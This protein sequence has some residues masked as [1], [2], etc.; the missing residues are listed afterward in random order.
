M[1]VTMEDFLK[2]VQKSAQTGLE[3]LRYDWLPECCAIIDMRRDEVEKWMPQD[4]E[5][6]TTN[7]D[8]LLILYQMTY[9]WTGPN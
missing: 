8:M 3:K 4:D 6:K 1:P 7:S 5:V 9:F 2:H